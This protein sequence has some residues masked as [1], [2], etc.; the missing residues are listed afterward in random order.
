MKAARKQ[1]IVPYNFS[2]EADI[3][4]VNAY[5][6]AKFIHGQIILLYVI[7]QGDFIQQLLRTESEIKAI[8]AQVKTRLEK[9]AD[10]ATKESG[11]VVTTMVRRGKI[12]EE[13]LDSAREISARFIM[14]GKREV[15]P[16]EPGELGSKIT[17]IVR[18]ADTPV[19]TVPGK[20]GVVL[21]YQHIV[22][23]IDLTQRTREKVFNAISFGQHYNATVHL[24]SVLI[25]G[26]KARESRILKKMQRIQDMIQENDVK[27]TIKLYERTGKPIHRL[28]L[29]YSTE[30]NADLIMVMTH[31]EANRHDNYIGAVAYKIINESNIPVVSFNAGAARQDED[32]IFKP[33]VDP[34]NIWKKK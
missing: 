1:I 14:L 29:D 10:K 17:R 31:K 6:I 4:L 7:D 9:I 34:F 3:A 19:I 5:T 20:K 30:I 8:E 15:L 18:A 21:D 33:M 11:V 23:P 32:S 28:V 26:V 2:D 13:I 25:G 22:V 16:A 27:S 24:V 12:Y